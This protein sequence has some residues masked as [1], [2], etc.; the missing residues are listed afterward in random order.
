MKLRSICAL[1]SLFLSAA[2]SLPARA[3]EPVPDAAQ[4]AT[5]T[6]ELAGNY[7]A[8]VSIEATR[9]LFQRLGGENQGVM[10]V[11]GGRGTLVLHVEELG[12]VFAAPVI[13]AVQDDGFTYAGPMQVNVGPGGENNGHMSGHWLGD[14]KSFTAAFDVATSLCTVRGTIAAERTD[15]Q[16]QPVVQAAPPT[17][18]PPIYST[19][20]PSGGAAS[21]PG[22]VTAQAFANLIGQEVSFQTSN[23]LDRFMRHR[24][25]L[26][27]AEA[28][29]G[30]LGRA[31]STF[32]IDPG[33]AGKC[34][35]LESH[36]Y[37]GQFLRHQAWRIKLAPREDND[38]YKQDATFCM[39]S[40]LASSAGV[41]FESVNYPHHY[42]RHR[43]GELWVDDF[44]GSGLF[45]ADA[46]FNVTQPGGALLVR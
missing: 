46:T 14:H 2:V 23:Y 20:A 34:I 12:T 33:L 17:S 8:T 30:D 16:A 28:V 45:R 10:E 25:S 7:R 13:V 11:G 18:S 43:N 1:A 27:Y 44:D 26:G 37:S 42:I 6:D 21:A 38:T 32:R 24:N 4:S 3:Q 40:G 15:A 5:S 41:S 35:S 9:C 19:P 29:S 39:V 22:G 31:D 36:N